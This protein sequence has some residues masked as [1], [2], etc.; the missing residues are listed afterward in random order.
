MEI[1]IQKG[2]QTFDFELSF[3][4]GWLLIETPIFLVLLVSDKLAKE[5]DAM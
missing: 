3:S 4:W 2:S 5:L 1:T